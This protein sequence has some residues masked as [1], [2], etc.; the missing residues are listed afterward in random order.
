MQVV[1]RVGADA[2]GEDRR[3]PCD[4]FVLLKGTDLA[5]SRWASEG[6]ANRDIPDPLGALC[7]LPISSGISPTANPTPALLPSPKPP[8]PQPFIHKL[9][10]PARIPRLGW[11]KT[12]KAKVRSGLI[13]FGRVG[14]CFGI[15]VG[16][17]SRISP[18]SQLSPSSTL[19]RFRRNI[20][21]PLSY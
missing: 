7:S 11:G 21:A 9:H 10:H 18:T 13:A 1:L 12:M 3:A 19:V 15:L 4:V 20:S 6:T 8:P 14:I 16:P 2:G 17:H 5:R